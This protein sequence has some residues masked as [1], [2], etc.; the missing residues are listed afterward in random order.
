[1]FWYF[2]AAKNLIRRN[3]AKFSM[4]WAGLEQYQTRKKEYFWPIS[5]SF[6]TSVF[7]LSMTN[8]WIGEYQ[9]WNTFYTPYISYSLR[10]TKIF[11]LHA[12]WYGNRA[13]QLLKFSMSQ[14]VKNKAFFSF[15]YWELKKFYFNVFPETNLV[16]FTC[17]Q[18]SFIGQSLRENFVPMRNALDRSYRDRNY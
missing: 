9:N 5:E 11:L 7:K 6:Q 16:L 8:L 18:R 1:M 12:V 10:I 13:F 2:S 15:V 17:F 3:Q 4:V 14:E